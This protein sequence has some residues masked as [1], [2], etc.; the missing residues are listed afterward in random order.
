MS[1]T[2]GSVSAGTVSLPGDMQWV[3]EFTWLPTAA[4][5]EVAC[6]GALIIEESAQLAGRP[7]TLEGRLE[8]SVGFA[9]PD[10]ATILALRAMASVPQAAP[11]TLTLE[12]GRV[13]TVRFRHADGAIE[14]Q[15]LKHIVPAEDTDLYSLTLR[16]MQV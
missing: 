4:Q 16:L 6:N 13:F 11:L 1:I 3:D 2:L 7:I 14:A 15:P 5:V 8:G 12:D 10:R 9:M